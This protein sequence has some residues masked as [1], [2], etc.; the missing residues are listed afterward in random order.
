[1]TREHD[2]KADARPDDRSE[3][4]EP[5]G[6]VSDEALEAVSGGSILPLP[7]GPKIPTLPVEPHIYPL[8]IDP[9]RIDF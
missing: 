4:T 9:R 2:E 1:M 5:Q 3:T 6:S 8:P 7:G